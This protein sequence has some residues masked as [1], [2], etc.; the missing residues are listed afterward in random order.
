MVPRGEVGVV[1][2]QLGLSMGVLSADLFAVVLFMAVATT[3]LA[4][5]VLTRL[6]AGE[7]SRSSWTSLEVPADGVPEPLAET[8]VPGPAEAEGPLPRDPEPG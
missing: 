5:P 7:D 1:V 8:G 3:L 2:A 4:P 6:F